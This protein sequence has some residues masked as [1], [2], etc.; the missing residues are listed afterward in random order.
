MDKIE[1]CDITLTSKA[2]EI[3]MFNQIKAISIATA[4]RCII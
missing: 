4:R 2:I 3:L 1:I